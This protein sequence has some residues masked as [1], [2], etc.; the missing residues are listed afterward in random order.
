M[1]CFNFRILFNKSSRRTCLL[2][3]NAKMRLWQ[4]HRTGPSK[5]AYNAPIAP[6]A[7]SLAGFEG[8]RFAPKENVGEREG[9]R[10]KEGESERRKRPEINFCLRPRRN[11]WY[12]CLQ[13]YNLSVRNSRRPAYTVV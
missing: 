13:S 2:A 1:T 3:P 4:G 11:R 5:E 7:D 10:R 12:R 6:H 8:N 9:K